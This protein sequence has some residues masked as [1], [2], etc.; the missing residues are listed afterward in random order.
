MKK[1]RIFV[2][3][4]L[5]GSITMCAVPGMARNAA[6]TIEAVYSDIKL[7]V[8][9]TA[10]TPRDANGK[11]VEPFIYDGTTYLPVRAVANA[12]GQ[13]VDWDEST[14]TVM[15]GGG[16]A[17]LTPF[18]NVGSLGVS[19][20]D[21]SYSYLHST[22]G[23][24]FS[25]DDNKSIEMAI[26]VSDED[27]RNRIIYDDLDFGRFT[28]TLLPPA[29]EANVEVTYL[30]NIYDGETVENKSYKLINSSSP[31]DVDIPING[32]QVDINVYISNGNSSDE[33][34]SALAVIRNPTIWPA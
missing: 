29:S 5:I 4:L 9:G 6:E 23:V 16:S 24:S 15:I 10:V 11:E 12:L 25:H 18:I 17:V 22:D 3:G 31:V 34:V 33:K 19:L 20:V 1:P 21:L 28:C 14:H 26:G 32:K 30:L 27:R 13:A 7:I 2:L 8:N